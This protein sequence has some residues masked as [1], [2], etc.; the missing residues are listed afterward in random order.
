MNKNLMDKYNIKKVVMGAS[1][2]LAIDGNYLN[3]RK[4]EVVYHGR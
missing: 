4:W 1:F 3:L 2:M